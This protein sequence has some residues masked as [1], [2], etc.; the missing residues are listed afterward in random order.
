L[1]DGAVGEDQRDVDFQIVSEGG[2]RGQDAPGR[3][4]GED[5]AF[6]Q[7]HEHG[8]GEGRD[9]LVRGDERAVQIEG[10]QFDLVGF[11]HRI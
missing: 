2:H 4:G 11:N 8:F 7:A 10:E 1:Q 5:A 6:A 9:C 3:D